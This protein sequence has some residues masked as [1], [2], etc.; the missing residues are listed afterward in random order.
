MPEL[1]YVLPPFIGHPLKWCTCLSG[2]PLIRYP[3]L[4]NSAHLISRQGC[5]IGF[6]QECEQGGGQ[7][8]EQGHEL[9]YEQG[10]EQGCEQAREQGCDQGR[11][12]G[13]DQSCSILGVFYHF[14]KHKSRGMLIP[15]P[16]EDDF[17]K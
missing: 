10:R 4:H 14:G 5:E 8:Y 7:N 2:S 13:Y 17:E 3:R 1:T 9:G 11:K 16:T 12:Q 6:E 15:A